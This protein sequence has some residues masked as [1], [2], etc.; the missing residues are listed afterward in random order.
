[1]SAPSIQIDKINFQ[2]MQ[3]PLPQENLPGWLLPYPQLLLPFLSAS[4]APS[5]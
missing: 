1:M 3:A 2:K 4:G 5:A